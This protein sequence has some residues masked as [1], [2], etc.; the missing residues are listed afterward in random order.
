MGKPT[1]KQKQKGKSENHELSMSEGV[2]SERE[3]T[4]GSVSVASCGELSLPDVAN[5]N[6]TSSSSLSPPTASASPI[7]P[8]A[9][10]SAPL[11]RFRGRIN[12]RDGELMLDSGSSSN[13]ISPSFIRKHGLRTQELE[14]EQ[15][16][17]L[18]D[19]REHTVRRGIMNAVVKWD[20]WSGTV[21]LLVLPLQQYD[22]ILGMTWLKKYNP[23]INWQTGRVSCVAIHSAA[24]AESQHNEVKSKSN[25]WERQRQREQ[26]QVDGVMHRLS[27]AA[28]QKGGSESGRRLTVG[29]SASSTGVLNLLTAEEWVKE[30]RRT[31]EEDGQ[32]E[33]GIVVVR[34]PVGEQVEVTYTT[35]HSRQREAGRMSTGLHSIESQ[36]SRK[37]GVALDAILR[38]YDD[39]FPDDLPTG[40]PQQR[41]VDHRI[42][43]LPGS[44]PTSR[45]AY[46]VSPADSAELKKQLDDLLAHGFITPSTSPYGAP[47]LFVKKKDGSTRM[48]VDYRALN[49]I[50]KKDAS[51]LPLMDQ[52]FDRV[53]GATVFTK[54]DLRSGYHQ[55][56]VHPDDTHKTAFNTRYGHYEF[57]VLPF[58][59]TNAPATFSTLM[60]TIFRPYIDQFVV[61]F[62]DD[63]LV[64][65][66]SEKEH[67]QHLRQVLEILRKEKLY[68]KKSKCEF[69][70][71]EVNFL[72]HVLSADGLAVEPV[73]VK[74]IEE[75][76]P[77]KSVEEVRGF[78]GLAGFY[79]RF[80][81]NFSKKAIPLSELTKKNQQWKW[82]GE[83]QQAFESLKRAVSEAPVLVTADPSRPFSLSTDASGYAIGA[84]LQQDQGQ[85]LQPIAYMSRKLHEAETRYSVGEQ[86]LL[87]IKTALEVWRHYLH[88]CMVNVFTD[89]RALEFIE[90]QKELSGRQ[91][92]WMEVMSQYN[93][94]IHYRP[95]KDNQVA[96]ALS[97][98]ADHKD[99]DD[100][101]NRQQQRESEHKRWLA[102][103]QVSQRETQPSQHTAT[104]MAVTAATTPVVVGRQ[105]WRKKETQTQTLAGVSVL[106]MTEIADRIKTA[107]KADSEESRRAALQLLQA[108]ETKDN[109]QQA[110]R[111]KELK[112]EGWTVVDGLL[113]Y[114][115]RLY[116][117]D[118]REL[119][120]DLWMEAHDSPLSGHLGMRKTNLQ[121]A[122]SYYWP[123]MQKEGKAYVKSC[124][125]CASTKSSTQRP[126]GLLQPL[127]VPGDRFETMSMDFIT[128]LPVTKRGKNTVLVVMVNKL[129]KMVKLAPT[130]TT[131]R[132]V[133]VAEIVWRV[134]VR[135][136]GVPKRIVSDRDPRFASEFW[137]ELWRLLG[138]KLSMSTAYHPQTDGQTENTNKTVENMLRAYVNHHLDDWDE[139]L[140]SA[141][142]AINNAVQDST[143]YSPYYLTFGQHLNF[144]LNVAAH[145]S[146]EKESVSESA[147]EFV[148]RTG[149][150]VEEARKRLLAE[151]EKQRR[152][153]NKHRREVKYK[154]GDMVMLETKHLSTHNSKLRPKFVGPFKIVK[155]WSDVNVEL[156]LPE[157]MEI[158]RKVHVEKL[159]PFSEDVAR[160]PTRTQI[161]RQTA[162]FGK[163]D[164]AEYEVDK[165]V[166]ERK[167]GRTKEYLV[168]WKNWPPNDATWEKLSH[169]TNAQE[170]LEDW[171]TRKEGR[172]KEQEGDQGQEERERKEQN[173]WEEKDREEPVVVQAEPTGR[174]DRDHET[175]DHEEEEGEYSEGSARQLR[176][177]AR[178]NRRRTQR[179]V[180]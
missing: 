31:W 171:D 61:V 136:Y 91:A 147:A 15:R 10:Y 139:H 5:R 150:L 18:A 19:G 175:S 131:F 120:T 36:G 20:G 159:K 69:F 97:R 96:D 68:A 163:R 155:V 45:S 141:E 174:T 13:F 7:P 16:V 140:V 82:G 125:S 123:H 101:S 157:V 116:V 156:D 169:L 2:E 52:L 49:K 103:W 14:T 27:A 108:D 177:S 119:R 47:V 65:S 98:R 144:P 95:G 32:V 133:D 11:I 89:N 104:D 151:Q 165:I 25:E 90:S 179:K 9:P 64:Y 37:L 63:I 33:G 145:R 17:R 66:R 85:G 4:S 29:E 117:P 128:Q 41:A 42:E 143:G 51:G 124:L 46:R 173:D 71:Q 67:E 39:V 126:A 76:P 135:E 106:V 21:T 87:A 84:V 178:L 3:K 111:R 70:Q 8:L 77:C 83:Q 153:A 162:V 59:L 107:M 102:I 88:G 146:E 114:R 130:K 30:V 94:K 164:R 75:W 79:R 176:R 28:M 56:R 58:G 134:W 149:L 1:V 112:G 122:R 132:A 93:Y 78:L 53:L 26:R 105:Q 23:H 152:Q 44:A 148:R 48:C 34:H 158:G 40:L 168:M 72:G 113:R 142:M 100:S 22:V 55:I 74:A 167:S 50:T 109:A 62:L 160:F 6:T 38:E 118:N 54:L 110:L 170:A 43:L 137:R 180:G 129:T 172:G 80:V 121:L 127:P 86:E 166:D 138:T 73:K 24:L 81:P 60:H 12:G 99:R 35:S 115:G 154:E 161:N 57:R 92:R